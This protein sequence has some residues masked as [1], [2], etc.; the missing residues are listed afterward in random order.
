M[1]LFPY[2]PAVSRTFSK[3]LFEFG[4]GDA[5]AEVSRTPRVCILRAVMVILALLI[6][7]TQATAECVGKNPEVDLKVGIRVSPPFVF[8]E[9]IR[10]LRGLSV[11]LWKSIADDLAQDE[12]FDSYEFVECSLKD[13]IDALSNGDLD[14][15]I[16]PLTITSARLENF[17][18]SHQYLSSG[19]TVA[20]RDSASIH[21]GTAGKIVKDAL[22]D[23]NILFG[24]MYFAV[25]NLILAAIIWMLWR[26][27]SHALNAPNIFSRA[28]LY[29]Y[30]AAVRT[31]GFLRVTDKFN[32]LTGRILETFMIIVGLALSTVVVGVV[33]SALVGSLGGT[34]ELVRRDLDGLR[35]ATLAE[36]TG[37][38]F[39]ESLPDRLG[40]CVLATTASAQDRCLTYPTW[41][42]AAQALADGS[43][44]VVIGDWIQLSY[45]ERDKKRGLDIRVQ[46]TTFFSEPYGW[47]FS[48]Q[49]TDLRKSVDLQLLK[50][51]RH[52]EWRSFVQEYIGEG[53]ISSQ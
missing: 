22:L 44:D 29:F 7:A 8:T 6:P 24:I 19:L 21:F 45:L 36:S 30:E 50:R 42:D 3:W 31:I 12:S 18:F 34:T 11:D 51:T 5:S 25:G 4:R 20:R 40:S 16:S 1:I 10:G 17:E 28:I 52:E 47:G 13:Q 9:D 2:I 37:E 35:I 46:G 53:S 15:V 27:T 43:V 32:T 41:E 39:V 38:A 14:V 33:T 26:N 48:P 49:R 23:K